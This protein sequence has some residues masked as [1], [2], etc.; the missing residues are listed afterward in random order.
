MAEVYRAISEMS[1]TPQVERRRLKPAPD[2][3]SLLMDFN[4]LIG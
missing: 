4:K 1:S 3:P 2:T